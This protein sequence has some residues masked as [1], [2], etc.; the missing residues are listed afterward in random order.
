[1]IAFDHCVIAVPAIQELTVTSS[2]WPADDDVEVVGSSLG[3][4]AVMASRNG[5]HRRVSG[6]RR[7]RES[8]GGRTW[9]IDPAAFWQVHPATP[10]TLTDTVMELLGQ[11]STL[12]RIAALA[13]TLSG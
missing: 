8:A 7:V 6:P 11:A 3:D 5:H 2:P 9:R 10:D 12:A 4:V 13:A 1:M